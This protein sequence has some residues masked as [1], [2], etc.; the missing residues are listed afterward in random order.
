MKRNGTKS[1]LC[2]I[3]S[4]DLCN[5]RYSCAPFCLVIPPSARFACFSHQICLL[6]VFRVCLRLNSTLTT[7][8]YDQCSS[9]HRETVLLLPQQQ[10]QRD[11]HNACRRNVKIDVCVSVDQ[12]QVCRRRKST[13]CLSGSDLSLLHDLLPARSGV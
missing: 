7:R 3:A 4:F 11:T 9:K 2:S 10:I 13:V 12:Q 8:L 6:C 5:L 1:P